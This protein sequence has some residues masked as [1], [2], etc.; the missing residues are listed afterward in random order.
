M[1]IDYARAE[2]RKQLFAQRTLAEVKEVKGTEG[3]I[4]VQWWSFNP[5][6]PF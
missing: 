1:R 2:V 4:F 3:L 6:V 5:S